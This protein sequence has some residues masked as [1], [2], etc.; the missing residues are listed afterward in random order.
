MIS[1]E[2]GFQ[3]VDFTCHGY[4]NGTAYSGI[5]QFSLFSGHYWNVRLDNVEAEYNACKMFNLP[6]SHHWSDLTDDIYEEVYLSSGSYLETGKFSPMV[7]PSAASIL[8]CQESTDNC[9][10]ID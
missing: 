2:S 5:V 6:F 3:L 7:E 4:A 10:L 1:A 8:T 9:I